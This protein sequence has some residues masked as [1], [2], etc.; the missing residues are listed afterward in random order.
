MLVKKNKKSHILNLIRNK[1][2]KLFLKNLKKNEDIII[3]NIKINC[4]KK[5]IDTIFEVRNENDAHR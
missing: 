1:C 4:I 3:N 5:C 2:L